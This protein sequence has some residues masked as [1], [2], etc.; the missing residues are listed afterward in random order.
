MHN[1]I[2]LDGERLIIEKTDEL[3][4]QELCS[5]TM[6]GYSVS[7]YDFFED[8]LLVYKH[9]ENR[10]CLD[11]IQDYMSIG[12]ENMEPI[13]LAS[14]GHKFSAIPFLYN[15]IVNTFNCP[16]CRQGPGIPV[17]IQQQHVEN[18]PDQIWNCLCLFG[19]LSR[20]SA[21]IQTLDV[22]VGMSHIHPPDISDN[23]GNIIIR[24]VNPI[25]M[26]YLNSQ[27][28]TL[29]NYHLSVQTDDFY[30]IAI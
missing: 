30:V 23:H 14:C 4:D 12:M 2:E 20:T 27:I 1:I 5:L 28:Q 24:I 18:I 29:R 26:I 11:M 19:K 22:V 17:N 16:L 3:A 8:K 25:A 15:I 7:T 9:N 21:V 6:E 13:R 10:K